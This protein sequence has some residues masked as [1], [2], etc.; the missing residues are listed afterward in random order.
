MTR[1]GRFTHRLLRVDT[2]MSCDFVDDDI[3]IVLSLDGPTTV[4]AGHDSATLDHGDAVLLDRTTALGFRIL[5][6]TNRCYLVRLKALR[7]SS[8]P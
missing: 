4:A 2:P 7:T 1:R 3:A 5:P 6:A 8:P